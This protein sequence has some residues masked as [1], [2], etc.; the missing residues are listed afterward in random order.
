MRTGIEALVTGEITTRAEHALSRIQ[1]ILNDVQIK[2]RANS[3]KGSVGS[4]TFYEFAACFDSSSLHAIKVCPYADRHDHTELLSIFID[5]S[6]LSGRFDLTSGYV[7]LLPIALQMPLMRFTPSE[8]SRFLGLDDCDI[9]LDQDEIEDMQDLCAYMK[10]LP[11]FQIETQQDVGAAKQLLSWTSKRTLT[12]NDQVYM[13]TFCKQ[14][15]E[16][17]C[18]MSENPHDEIEIN[19]CGRSTD[20]IGNITDIDIAVI[21][22]Q[23]FRDQGSNA[24]LIDQIM[25]DVAHVTK[26][27]NFPV[28]IARQ[29]RMIMHNPTASDPHMVQGTMAAVMINADAMTPHDKIQAIRTW[30]NH[31][32]AANLIG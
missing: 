14:A 11:R 13:R 29:I 30:Q 27:K 3:K 7:T 17:L 9:V 2:G 16:A 5:G 18:A 26:G 6:A 4:V 24:Q 12:D 28:P 22:S 32:E 20:R 8:K 15:C 23:T 31:K 10:T 25:D 19:I 21:V 1:K